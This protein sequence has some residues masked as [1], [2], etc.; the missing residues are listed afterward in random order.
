M[1]RMFGN[2]VCNRSP[3]KEKETHISFDIADD[4]D[5][6]KSYYWFCKP[7]A[8]VCPLCNFIY[9]F[10]PLGFAFIGSE[11]VFINSNSTI[12]T[13]I[14][15]M[16]AQREKISET[17]N[18][19]V[20]KRIMRTFTEEKIDA[21]EKTNSNIQIILRSSNFSHFVFDVIDKD[22]IRNLKKGSKYLSMLE[23]KWVA[24]D[25]KKFISVYDNIFDMI[26]NKHS[27]YSFIDKALKNEIDKSNNI[28]Y[29]KGVLRL[30]IIFNG[31]TSMDELNKKIDFAF[32]SGKALRESILGKEAAKSSENGAEAD[33]NRLRGLVYRLVNLTA[34]GDCSQFIDTVIR[35]YAG[36]GLTIPTVFKDCYKSDEMFKAI[37]HGFILGLKYAAY[38]KNNDKQ[39]D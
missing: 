33:D 32:M 24:F 13:L 30:E 18:L 11:A 28:N 3:K 19:S 1:Y 10:I 9:A 14:K 29:L 25:S 31:G 21:L 20:R 17:S 23:K 38:E 26:L 22:M 16:S 8:Y 5:R 36:Y 12:E 7:D 37:S 15:I 6:K 4:L 35:I 39:E 27:L 34:V 2:Y